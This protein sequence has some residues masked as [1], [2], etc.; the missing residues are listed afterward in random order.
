MQCSLYRIIAG[1]LSI[2]NWHSIAMCELFK[3]TIQELASASLMPEKHQASQISGRVWDGSR[4][5]ELQSVR[6]D[7]GWGRGGETEQHSS[8]SQPENLVRR[9]DKFFR[10]SSWSKI[11][12]ELHP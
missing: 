3:D 7:T 9:P 2:I 6:A 11:R 10:D 8:S 12:C 1:K 5:H 4:S